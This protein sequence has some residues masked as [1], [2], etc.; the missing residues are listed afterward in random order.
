MLQIVKEKLIPRDYKHA[1]EHAAGQIST[2]LLRCVLNEIKNQEKFITAKQGKKLIRD[3][4]V[5]T[6]EKSELVCQFIVDWWNITSK[7]GFTLR[8]VCY[9]GN[10]NEPPEP[11]FPPRLPHY[12]NYREHQVRRW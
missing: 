6:T 7:N 11:K 12:S 5:D 8:E 4:G 10:F 3:L 1:L 2:I 9:F